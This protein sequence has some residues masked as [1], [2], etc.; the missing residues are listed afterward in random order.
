MNTEEKI[1][2]IYSRKS[3]YTGVG[4][5]IQNQ[6]DSSKRLLLSKY[7]NVN[8]K[9]IMIFEDEGFSGGNTKRPAFQ[10]MLR[11]LEEDRLQCIVA[12]RLDRISRSVIDFVDL[13]KIIDAH[14]TA[15]HLVNDN[16]DIDSYTGR[17]MLMIASIFA[18]MER[19]IIRERITDNL[20]G[21]AKT[22]RWLGGATPTGYCSVDT[23][24]DNHAKMLQLIPAEADTIKLI[25]TKY[26]EL[27]SLTGL[28]T[29]CLQHAINTKTNTPHTRLSLQN[30]LSNPVY[31]AADQQAKK[32]FESLGCTIYNTDE[33]RTLDDIFDGQHAMLIY[34]KLNE[35]GTTYQANSPEEWIVTVGKHVPIISSTQW[36]EV[37]SILKRNSSKSYRQPRKRSATALLSSLLHCAHCGGYMR[38][39]TSKRINK[40]GELSYRYLCELAHKSKKERC[41]CVS[42]NGN[43]L[44]KVVMHEIIQ[45]SSEPQIVLNDLQLLQQSY[46][47]NNDFLSKIKEI[48]SDNTK[49]GKEVKKLIANMAMVDDADIVKEI[50]QAIA[51]RKQSIEANNARLVEL[52][53]LISTQDEETK[54]IDELIQYLTEFPAIFKD[55]NFDQ[56]RAALRKIVHSVYYDSDKKQVTINLIGSNN[57]ISVYL[58]DESRMRS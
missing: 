49:L 3:K 1:Y 55:A 21:L 19:N 48:E 41:S 26:L 38:P 45:M 15:L 32:Y 14:H 34:R 57:P 7:P 36:I 29:Y 17:S 52:N 56:K 46:Q 54:A 8:E 27:Q 43:V 18:E 6:I 30:I 25:F 9:Q 31:C 5:S 35:N 13:L 4:E 11:L 12:N 2:A 37:Q 33:S 20:L 47:S 40:Q 23:G 16:Y 42:V 24:K 51:E 10:Q 22:G 58:D 44:D 39:Q 53:A 50:T 28:E